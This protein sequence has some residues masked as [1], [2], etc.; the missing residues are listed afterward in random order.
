MPRWRPPSEV[1]SRAF[2]TMSSRADIQTPITASEMRVVTRIAEVREAVRH[3]RE[4]GQRVA[5]V[6]TMGFLHSGHL[7]LAEEGTRRVGC[8]VMSIFV[9]PLQFGPSED[10]G[11]YPRNADRDIE[12]ARDAG[13]DVVFMPDTAEMYGAAP[14]VVVTPRA[15]ADRWEGA[16]RPGHF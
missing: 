8:T 6:P 1:R 4:R 15:A 2:A 11:R 7:T 10:F 5:L 9:N 3:A 16:V 13:V 12:L 14:T